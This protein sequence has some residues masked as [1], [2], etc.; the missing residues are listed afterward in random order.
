MPTIY[1]FTANDLTGAPVDLRQYQGQV[2]LI[3][4]TASQCG[5]T[6][7]YQG[8]EAVYQQFRDRGVVV[9]GFP[10]NQFGAQEPGSASEIGAFCEKNYGVT[11]PLFAKIDVNGAQAHPLFAKLKHDAPGVLGTERIKWNFTKFLVRKD[12]TVFA[13]YA[14]TTK[15]ESIVADIEKLLLE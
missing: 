11:F 9:L 8:L 2:L 14:P 4:N 1:D 6:P 10:C 15:P 7:Q 5:F 12:G 13:R 3:V